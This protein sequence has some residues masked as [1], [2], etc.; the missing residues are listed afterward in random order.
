VTYTAPKL[1]GFRVVCPAHF[2]EHRV[3]TFKGRHEKKAAA[4]AS[5]LGEVD[6]PAAALL[7]SAI[8]TATALVMSNRKIA[9]RGRREPTA[10]PTAPYARQ[11]DGQ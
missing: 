6:L 9:G 2:S 1:F 4:G 5:Q 10:A 11:P 8:K 3:D 7:H